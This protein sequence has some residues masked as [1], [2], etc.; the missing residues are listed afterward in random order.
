MV[1]FSLFYPQNWFSMHFNGPFG[2]NLY[3]WIN[4]KHRLFFTIAPSGGIVNSLCHRTRWYAKVKNMQC[5]LL[6]IV[7]FKELMWL[8]TR[9]ELVT[10]R[11]M[12]Y[13][14]FRDL[15]TLDYTFIPCHKGVYNGRSGR[16]LRPIWPVM[17]KI[18]LKSILKIQNKIVFSKYFSK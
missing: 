13:P 3:H 5:I 1:K 17:C 14:A 7:K 16:N 2:R 8:I 15:L 10:V 18:P 11:P 4:M 12:N 6:F 9:N